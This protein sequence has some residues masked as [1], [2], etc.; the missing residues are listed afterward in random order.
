MAPGHVWFRAR[1]NPMTP[2]DES[3]INGLDQT[4]LET[5]MT[6][7]LIS[8]PTSAKPRVRLQAKPRHGLEEVSLGAQMLLELHSLLDREWFRTRHNVQFRREPWG[9]EAA[10]VVL[11]AGEVLAKWTSLRDTLA[12][13]AISSESE[14]RAETLACAVSFTCEF[15]D[16]SKG[17]SAKTLTRPATLLGA[18]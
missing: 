9:E 18:S 11:R 12:F 1:A 15:L 4:C 14:A 6:G 17:R 16:N 10:V 13:K 7:T 3:S 8:E 2:A 5:I